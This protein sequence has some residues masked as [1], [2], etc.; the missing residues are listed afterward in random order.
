MQFD[1]SQL[2]KI[3]D[4]NENLL[5]YMRKKEGNA[6]NTTEQIMLSYDLQAGAYTD[7]YK[8]KPQ[9]TRHFLERLSQIIKE[10][11]ITGTVLE[12]GVGEANE[13]A[14]LLNICKEKNHVFEKVY[15]LDI[16]WSRIKMAKRFSAEQGQ[17]DIEFCTGDML[18]L[19]YRDNSIDLVLTIHA[20]ESN[21]GKEKEIL[22]EL[23]RVSK[24]YLILMEP[25]FEFAN[26]EARARM[27]KHGYVTRLYETA[28]ELGYNIEM[29][30]LYG[31]SGNEL[32]PTGL[33]IIRKNESDINMMQSPYACP[34]SK[35]PMV[36]CGDSYYCDQSMLAYPIIQ[37]IPCL[38][39]NN[40]VV[41]TKYMA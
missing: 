33:M 23:Y 34:L 27:I 30:E 15:G 10:K 4:R 9:H 14:I 2:K 38:L 39:P 31:V 1:L 7:I 32:N 20:I 41:A 19:P 22:E 5:E 24:K 26:E 13:L 40:A 35:K 37:G 6:Y 36:L 29:Y 28:K 3:Y 12:A 25:C 11:D 17:N 18:N 8:T 16:S 21:G